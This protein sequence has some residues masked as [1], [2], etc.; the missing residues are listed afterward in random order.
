MLSLYASSN[1]YY[2]YSACNFNYY[3]ILICLLTSSSNFYNYFS[4]A[5]GT[6][7]SSSSVL[8]VSI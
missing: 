3:S 4:Y 7:S 2:T 1:Y 6:Y 5:S 8:V